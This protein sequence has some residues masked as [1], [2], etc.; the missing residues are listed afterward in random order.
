MKL[1]LLV[2]K[3]MNKNFQYGLAWFLAI[4]GLLALYLVYQE[5]PIKQIVNSPKGK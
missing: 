3:F 5:V 4:G 1:T 2:S